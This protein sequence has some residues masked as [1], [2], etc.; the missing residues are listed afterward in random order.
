MFWVSHAEIRLL[1]MNSDL[2]PMT[3]ISISEN[4]AEIKARLRWADGVCAAACPNG[5]PQG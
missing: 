4:G 5:A 1:H 2:C 3:A